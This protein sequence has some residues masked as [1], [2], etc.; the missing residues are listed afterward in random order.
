MA[1]SLHAL[2]R[3][4]RLRRKQALRLPQHTLVQLHRHQAARRVALV[5]PQP[6]VLE[7]HQ[8]PAA[9]ITADFASFR[10]PQR[11]QRPVRG[12]LKITA[13]EKARAFF[14]QIQR[15]TLRIQITPSV[16]PHR[17][18]RRLQQRLR[19]LEALPAPQQP[20]LARIAR[21]RELALVPSRAHPHA[22]FIT[23]GNMVF[24]RR[25]VET[26]GHHLTRFQI[27]F[28]RKRRIAAARAEREQHPVRLLHIVRHAV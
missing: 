18:R 12:Y 26:V 16:H 17:L 19:L 6:I 1:R 4:P 8:Q 13:A 14:Q 28:Q 25:K 27:K 9:Q 23:P 22:V 15:R 2:H 5:C 20:R 24:A 7:Q 11:Q 10:Q 3:L 21:S